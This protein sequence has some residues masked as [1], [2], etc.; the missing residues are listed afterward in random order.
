MVANCADGG[1]DDAVSRRLTDLTRTA[2]LQVRELG[3]KPYIAPGLS[4]AAVSILRLLRGE[5][6]Y[7][8]VPLG[9][10]YFGCVSRMTR[11]GVLLR[12]EKICEE[13]LQRLEETHRVLREFDYS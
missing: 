6:H 8:A 1:Y 7:G 3:F 12:R 9:G 11:G 13:L 10:A 4:S 2:N 5:E